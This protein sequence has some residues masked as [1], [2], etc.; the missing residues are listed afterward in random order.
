M[1]LLSVFGLMLLMITT[2]SAEFMLNE[3]DVFI[4]D[5]QPDGSAKVTESIKIIIKG[6]D[7]Q[8][9]YDRGFAMNDLAF[10]SSETGISHIRQHVN[11]NKV[12]IKDLRVK[13]QPRKKCNPFQGLCHGEL[14]IEYVATP[15]YDTNGTKIP[16]TGLFIVEQ[17][18]PR[19]VRYTINPEALSFTTTQLGHILLEEN[20]HLRIEV[21]QNAVITDLNPM[22]EQI[23]A[24][25]PARISNLEWYDTIL[26]KFSVVFEVEE[27]LEKEVSNFFSSLFG[28]LTRA[29]SGEYGGPIIAIV[30]IIIGGYLYITIEKR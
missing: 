3:V 23:D 14:V 30:I 6:E 8:N 16:K 25:L 1:R 15:V 18:K 5:V 19:T 4:H 17:Y 13:P 27:T 26:V 22:P 20:V 2:T 11:P 9:A 29:L 12:E 24:R 10:W 28:V 21:P 7:A